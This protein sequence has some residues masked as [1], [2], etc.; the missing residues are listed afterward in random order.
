[1]LRRKQSVCCGPGGTD[2]PLRSAVDTALSSRFFD[3]LEFLTR[4]GSDCATVMLNDCRDVVF[5]SDL[6]ATPFPAEIV[7]AQQRCRLGDSDVNSRG[8]CKRMARQLPRTIA[9]YR[10]E[11]D[12][13]GVRI[14]KPIRINL[15][16]R[17][18]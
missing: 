1:M 18:S 16:L 13:N 17:T 14:L 15:G 10:R 3:Y 5:Q 4:H 7:Y 6:F 2:E 9:Y 11:H 8:S 12:D